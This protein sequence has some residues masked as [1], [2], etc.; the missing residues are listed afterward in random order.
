MSKTLVSEQ[1]IVDW[2]NNRLKEEYD[3][4]FSIKHVTQLIA[5]NH[6]GCNWSDA[7]Q[8]SN[9]GDIGIRHIID[10]SQCLFNLK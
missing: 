8:V 9:G 3:G 7:I 1:E 6:N 2:I 4:D 10:E 5:L